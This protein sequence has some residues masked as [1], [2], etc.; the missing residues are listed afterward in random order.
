MPST[1]LRCDG[2]WRAVVGVGLL[3]GGG[4]AEQARADVLG[5]WDFSTLTGGSNNFGPSPLAATTSAASITVGGLTRGVGVGTTGG[6]GAARAWGG[7]PAVCA[8]Y[9]TSQR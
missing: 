3:V 6:S 1:I 2:L 8:V 4:V 7:A 5:G 9:R